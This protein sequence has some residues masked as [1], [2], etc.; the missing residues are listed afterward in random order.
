MARGW[1]SKAVE[2]QQASAEARSAAPSGRAPSAEEQAREAARMI[3]QLERSRIL[4]DLQRACH[5]HHCGMLEAAL[6]DVD[7]RIRTA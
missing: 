6:A 2:D 7:E 1:E 5:P 3:L 4:Q